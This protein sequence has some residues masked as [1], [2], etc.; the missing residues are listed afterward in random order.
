MTPQILMCPPTYFTVDY[1]INPW[2]T[3]DAAVDK[4]LAHEQWN[5]LKTAIQKAGADVLEVD[6]VDGLPDMVFTANAGAVF[7]RNVVLARYRYPERQGEEPYM[8]AWFKANGFTVHHVPD[9]LYFEGMGDALVWRDEAGNGLVFAGYRMRTN[10]VTHAY[11]QKALGLPVI[12]ME[13]AKPKFY[14]IDV[15]M[16]PTDRGDLIYYPGAFDSYGNRVIETYVP[17]E[18]RITIDED[19]AELF[20][21]NSVSINNTIIFNEGSKKLRRK[22]EDRGYTVVEVNMSEFLKSGGSCK[23]LTLRVQ[24]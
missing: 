21:G 5:N 16:C 1:S 11:L 14:H 15:C 22:L 6:P 9:D 4:A 19:E 13:L 7:N 2:M 10:I 12:S 17:E 24:Q 8:D 3:Q 20:A 23:C 18:R